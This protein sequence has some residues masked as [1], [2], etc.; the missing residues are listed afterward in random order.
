[1]GAELEN[2]LRPGPLKQQN[3]A[4]KL[5]HGNGGMCFGKYCQFH[6]EWIAFRRQQIVHLDSLQ[7]Q[8]V[9]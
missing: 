8:E 7:A 2:T 9:A 5:Q 4:D 3:E 1:M 6:P